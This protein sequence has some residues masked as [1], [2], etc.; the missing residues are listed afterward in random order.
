M[1]ISLDINQT[2][3]KELKR[4]LKELPGKARQGLLRAIYDDGVEVF[5]KSQE[6]VPVLSGDL[7]A[8]GVLTRPTMGNPEVE[9]Y[10][11]EDHALPVHE[12]VQ[13]NTFK[14]GKQSHYLINPYNEVMG[15]AD[16]GSHLEEEMNNNIKNN[17]GISGLKGRKGSPGPLA[18]RS[19]S[20][21]H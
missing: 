11:E 10:Y 14:H 9:I 15:G 17:K 13:Q 20:R 8:S 1:E 16:Y 19:K 21:N 4:L 3:M 5:E 6:L 2:G 12:N 7:R 18:D